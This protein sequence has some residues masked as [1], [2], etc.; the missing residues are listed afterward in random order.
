MPAALWPSARAR[1]ADPE[2]TGIVAKLCP[3]CGANYDLSTT[4]CS[5]DGAELVTVN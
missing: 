4:V 1:R 2:L 5:K 3:R